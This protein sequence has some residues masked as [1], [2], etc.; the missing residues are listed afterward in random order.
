LQ[1]KNKL[2]KIKN[3]DKII[4][5]KIKI[6][7]AKEIIFKTKKT[8]IKIKIIEINIEIDAKTS[9]K[10]TAIVATTTIDRKYLLKLY[11]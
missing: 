2:R 5:S 8:E 3:I 4:I 6:K 11:K 10:V 1:L 9:A 7:K